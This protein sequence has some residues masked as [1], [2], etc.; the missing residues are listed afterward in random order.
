MRHTQQE[1][2]TLVN[3]IGTDVDIKG[4]NIY[5]PRTNLGHKKSPVGNRTVQAKAV[6]EK[7]ST[8]TQALLSC[9]CA[10]QLTADHLYLESIVEYR[11]IRDT[12]LQKEHQN[13]QDRRDEVSTY[14]KRYY[15]NSLEMRV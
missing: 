7:T 9:G 13:K 15:Q 12:I 11:S 4:K 14:G 6:E 3:E 2:I 8:L 10:A 5:T 1:T